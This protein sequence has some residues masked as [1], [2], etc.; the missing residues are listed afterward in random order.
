MNQNAHE[1]WASPAGSGPAFSEKSNHTSGCCE[2]ERKQ[3][4]QNDECPPVDVRH[5]IL[6]FK[7]NV[8]AERLR[9]LQPF[10]QTD[11]LSGM[12]SHC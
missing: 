3:V 9:P 6:S 11:W 8:M 5:A 7:S 12:R 10:V 4:S 1:N 2:R